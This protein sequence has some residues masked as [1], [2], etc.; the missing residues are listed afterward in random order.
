VAK[1]TSDFHY[2]H[3]IRQYTHGLLIEGQF[4]PS[5]TDHWAV[6]AKIRQKRPFRW[7]QRRNRK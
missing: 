5:S 6:W 4:V 2:D 3:T 1:A 7:P